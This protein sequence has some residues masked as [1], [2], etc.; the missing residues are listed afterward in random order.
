MGQFGLGVVVVGKVIIGMDGSIRLYIGIGFGEALD[1]NVSY[2]TDAGSEP[3]GGT[4]SAD[5]AAQV[6]VG[7]V[8]NGTIS[9]GGSS[10]GV[11]VGVGLGEGVTV[12]GGYTIQIK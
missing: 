10:T 1:G 11:G 12:T 5:A 8:G 3:K 9:Q 7:P 2:T 6:G 4:I